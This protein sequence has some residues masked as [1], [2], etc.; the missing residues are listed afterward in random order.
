MGGNQILLVEDNL[1][2]PQVSL[3]SLCMFDVKHSSNKL[4][5]RINKSLFGTP[6]VMFLGFDSSLV[7][8]IAPI[9]RGTC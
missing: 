3:P 9:R 1:S 8:Q 5:K 2:S 6:A 7:Q 4:A